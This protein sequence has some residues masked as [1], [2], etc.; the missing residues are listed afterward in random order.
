MMSSFCITS[1]LECYTELVTHLLGQ[2]R[3]VAL[4]LAD[5]LKV[6]PQATIETS[7]GVLCLFS[8]SVGG[9]SELL[10]SLGATIDESAPNEYLKKLIIYVC[11]PE[12]ELKEGEYK[13][14]NPVLTPEEIDELSEQELEDIAKAYVSNNEYLFKKNEFC[15]KKDADGKEVHYSVYTNIEHPKQDGESYINYLHRLSCL[16]QDKQ[17]ERMESI[18]GSMPKLDSFSKALS[19]GIAKNLMFGDSIT[20]SIKS[21]RAAQ[22]FE[23]T[24]VRSPLESVD[25][26]KIERNRER[27]RREPF[28]D[29]AQRLDELI[30]SSIHASEFMVEAN[31]IQTE[32]ASEIKAGGDATDRHARNNINLSYIVILLTVSGLLISG[33][34]T[35]SGLSFSEEQQSALDG[36]TS[37]FFESMAL[38][39]KAVEESG[40]ESKIVQ[41]E[42]LSEL[43]N[44]NGNLAV[45]QNSMSDIYREM[46][47]LKTFNEKYRRKIEE[48]NRQIEE[49]KSTNE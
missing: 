8:I 44:L 9:Q 6:K 2:R 27:T 32:I 35:M 49:I 33:W 25:W 5:L 42:I 18:L 46:E 7:I 45:T 36:Y 12:S 22:N 30:S 41:N 10:K 24:P 11:F 4:N 17:K 38:T 47:M 20:N 19:G 40:N 16:E 34:S 43:K 14:D 23:F 1:Q 29:L 39:K 28:D 15:K 26:A 21:A 13:P 3:N 31:R 48:L 37:K